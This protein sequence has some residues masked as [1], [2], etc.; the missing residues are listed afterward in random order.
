VF[1]L[2]LTRLQVGIK[3]TLVRLHQE[4]PVGFLQSVR[5]VSGVVHTAGR[6]HDADRACF[7]RLVLEEKIVLAGETAW[8]V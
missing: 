7:R 8:K 3:L 6:Q 2:S 1:I 4:F 5:R